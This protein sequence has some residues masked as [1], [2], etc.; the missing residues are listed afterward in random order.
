MPRFFLA[1]MLSLLL[2]LPAL[3]FAQDGGPYP[4]DL[5]DLADVHRPSSP[6][7]AAVPAGF[8]LVPSAA[9]AA[10]PA[11]PAYAVPPGFTLQPI[12]ALAAPGAP[13]PPA[14]EAPVPAPAPEAADPWWMVLLRNADAWA[15]VFAVIIGIWR[16]F[17]A[18]SAEGFRAAFREAVS[19]AYHATEEDAAIGKLAKGEKGGNFLALF[20]SMMTTGGHAKRL[21]PAVTASAQA[22]AKALN[23]TA[24]PSSSEEAEPDPTAAPS[25]PSR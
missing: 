20:Q 16:F 11:A 22:A 2:G 18:K 15:L 12:A 5:D 14:L 13:P 24:P 25:R 17:D 3:A 1:L 9:R 21:G 19:I 10:L 6:A 7:P 4:V 8:E 23:A